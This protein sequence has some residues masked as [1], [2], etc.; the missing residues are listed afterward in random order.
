MVFE[1]THGVDFRVEMVE[2]EVSNLVAG[3]P[4][5]FSSGTTSR[6]K[7]DRFRYFRSSGGGTKKGGLVQC[8]RLFFSVSILARPSLSVLASELRPIIR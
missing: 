3:P 2:K 5:N 1:L 4:S 8:A 6:L 7:L